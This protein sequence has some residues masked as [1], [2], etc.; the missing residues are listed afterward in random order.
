MSSFFGEGNLYLEYSYLTNSTA[1]N[2]IITNSVINTSSL[3]MLNSSGNYQNITNTAS[4]IN[5]NDVAI[6]SYVDNLGISINQ[7]ILTSTSGSLINSNQVGAYVITV[8]TTFI[9]GP[10]GPNAIFNI[11]KS[12]PSKCGNVAMLSSAPG[13][14]S[15]CRLHMI[16]PAYSGPILFKSNVNYDGGYYVKNM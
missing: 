2:N 15:D 14:D 9:G 11:T 4:P 1:N 13:G 8:N 3:S 16:W 10:Y 5:P 6:K 12:D 7:I